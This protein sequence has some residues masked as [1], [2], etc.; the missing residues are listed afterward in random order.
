MLSRRLFQRCAAGGS[1][2]FSV[3]TKANYTQAPFATTATMTA[4]MANNHITS[5]HHTNSTTPTFCSIHS[6]HLIPCRLKSSSTLS[7]RAAQALSKNKLQNK[8]FNG[9]NDKSERKEEKPSTTLDSQKPS[10][11]KTEIEIK[12]TDEIKN[13]SLD[14]TK[15]DSDSSETKPSTAVNAK[16]IP[17]AAIKANSEPPPMTGARVKEGNFHE[18]APRICVVGVGGAGGNAVNNMI[19]SSLTGEYSYSFSSPVLWISSIILSD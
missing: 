10:T 13:N 5:S 1:P 7:K 15:T 9:N 16:H 18:F 6:V 17:D 19:A 3:T 12:E 4:T 11:T 8:K 2:L 14:E